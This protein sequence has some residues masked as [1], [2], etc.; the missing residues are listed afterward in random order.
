MPCWKTGAKDG[1]AAP[2]NPMRWHPAAV[3]NEPLDFV[4]GLRT[5]VVNGDADAQSGMAAHL[6]LMNRRWAGA[7]WSMPTARC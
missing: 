5:M 3:P 7:R 1:V 6:V 2:P 4:D